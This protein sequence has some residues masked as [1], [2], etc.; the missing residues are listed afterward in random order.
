MFYQENRIDV[1]L[2]IVS[3][4]TKIPM[5]EL[6]K[7]ILL[8]KKENNHTVIKTK[9]TPSAIVSLSNSGKCY[10]ETK[11]DRAFDFFSQY[12]VHK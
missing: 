7:I 3:A 6:I 4:K 8:P 10:F 11:R 12:S 5:N 2:E 9:D 1:N